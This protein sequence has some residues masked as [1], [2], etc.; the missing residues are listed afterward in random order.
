M[1]GA[2][3]GL[4]KINPDNGE[5]V[6]TAMLDREIQ[7]VFTLRGKGVHAIENPERPVM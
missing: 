2:S 3:S 5:V 6:T 7:E 4:F 1:P